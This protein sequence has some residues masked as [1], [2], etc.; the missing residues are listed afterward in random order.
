MGVIFNIQNCQLLNWSLPTEEIFQVYGQ[1][2]PVVN[3]SVVG[4]RS[5]PREMPLPK[6][7]NSNSFRFF[8]LYF[9]FLPLLEKLDCHCKWYGFFSVLAAVIPKNSDKWPWIEDGEGFAVHSRNRVARNASDVSAADWRYQTY[10]K[11]Y[12]IISR[13]LHGFFQGSESLYNAVL[14][15]I[16]CNN[17]KKAFNQYVI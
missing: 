8:F 10:L 16:K 11:K 12:D 14:Y 17:I 7:L 5:Q 9:G 4:F 6:P 1:N 13:V 15:M 3:L 2:R